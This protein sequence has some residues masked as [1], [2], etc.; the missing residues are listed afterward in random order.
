M[1]PVSAV[2]MSF[3]FS[4]WYFSHVRLETRS[5]MGGQLTDTCVTPMRRFTAIETFAAAMFLCRLCLSSWY[6]MTHFSLIL[7]MHRYCMT[8]LDGAA[9]CR[10][11]GLGGIGSGVCWWKHSWRIE[12]S[13]NNR[14]QSEILGQI[15]FWGDATIV[16]LS[17][18]FYCVLMS[19]NWIN[20]FFLDHTPS[21]QGSLE[22]KGGFALMPQKN[23]TW[24]LK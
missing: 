3:C 6:S 13:P 8:F 4:C 24:L 22:N 2:W 21:S 17:L 19:I 5:Q 18:W 1:N 9:L 20:F 7:R 12:Y 15:Q 16:H 11:E 23:H 10:W 14:A